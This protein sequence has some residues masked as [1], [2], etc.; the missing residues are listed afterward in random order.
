M[1]KCTRNQL[2]RSLHD[3]LPDRC[4]RCHTILTSEDKHHYSISC[5]VCNEDYWY[6]EHFDYFPI[7]CAWRYIRYQ[8]RWLRCATAAGLGVCLRK[9]LHWMVG[10]REQSNAR[11]E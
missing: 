10:K 7:R 4:H 9:V 5:E 6:A 11:R 3:D 1:I 2:K 8:L